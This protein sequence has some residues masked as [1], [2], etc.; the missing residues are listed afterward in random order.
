MVITVGVMVGCGERVGC[1]VVITAGLQ[2]EKNITILRTSRTLRCN[3]FM[4][5]SLFNNMIN[6]R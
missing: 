2:A 3:D 4:S 1:T 6:P 5:I